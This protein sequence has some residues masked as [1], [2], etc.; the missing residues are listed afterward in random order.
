MTPLESEL[1]SVQTTGNRYEDYNKYK[2][3]LERFLPYQGVSSAD[4]P[5]VIQEYLGPEPITE[6][7]FLTRTG[8][9]FS[10]AADVFQ[11]NVGAISEYTG[12]LSDIEWLKRFGGELYEEQ[13]K[14]L[15]AAPPAYSQEDPGFLDY[16]FQAVESAIGS[17]PIALAPTIAFAALPQGILAGIAAGTAAGIFT[18]AALEGGTTYSALKRQLNPDGTQR[19]TED[20]VLEI[21]NRI[22]VDNAVDPELLLWNVV[23]AIS[24]VK[25]MPTAGKL[26]RFGVGVPQQ[27]ISGGLQE[28]RQYEVSEARIEDPRAAGSAPYGKRFETQEGRTSM[29]VGAMAEG[30]FA[31][32]DAV[33]DPRV[34]EGAVGGDLTAAQR[35]ANKY[36]A[37]RDA[38]IGSK[39]LA[40]LASIK[41]FITP[42]EYAQRQQSLQSTDMAAVEIAAA[43]VSSRAE[44]V[45]RIYG[46]LPKEE[47]IGAVEVGQNR[48]NQAVLQKESPEG[49]VVRYVYSKD[50]KGFMPSTRPGADP[51][52]FITVEERDTAAAQ[53]QED[54]RLKAEQKAQEKVLK[55]EQ[56]Q[57]QIEDDADAAFLDYQEKFDA[58]KERV[59]E[60]PAGLEREL[61]ELEEYFK[62]YRKANNRLKSSIADIQRKTDIE[63]GYLEQ[64][65]LKK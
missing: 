12:E 36:R 18:N 63:R 15:E 20:Q 60:D 27:A 37:A 48:R 14:Q 8:R 61:V 7:G 5:R 24:P 25:V 21:A 4:I 28:G 57:K 16:G 9:T 47:L 64:G 31:A 22:A 56:D 33:I 29:I 34:Q 51:E 41:E 26:T 3:V 1:R 39:A 45:R 6:A 10:R 13:A 30:P 42:E 58:L 40:R 65:R 44:E 19:Y 49:E 35:D 2:S 17:A 32:I 62:A 43:E 23:Q 46:P 11:Q 52:I 59:G 54:N 55:K 53:R 50:L 38:E